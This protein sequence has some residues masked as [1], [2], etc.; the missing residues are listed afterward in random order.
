MRYR[1]VICS[2]LGLAS[3]AVALLA[4]CKLDDLGLGESRRLSAAGASCLR[5]D[6]CVPGTQCIGQVCVDPSAPSPAPAPAPNPTAAPPVASPSGAPASPAPTVAEPAGVPVGEVPNAQG[7]GAATVSAGPL[8]AG[9]E[10][11]KRS[12]EL[13]DQGYQHRQ[14]GDNAAARAAYQAALADSPSNEAARYNLACELA[15]T[16]DASDREEAVSHLQALLRQNT[17]VAR[18]FIAAVRFDTDFSS[19]A[20]DPRV[21]EL[22]SSVVVDPSQPLWPQLCDDP[23][24]FVSLVDGQTGLVEYH[25]TMTADESIKPIGP[26]T[27]ARTWNEARQAAVAFLRDMRQELCALAADEVSDGFRKA[28]LADHASSGQVCLIEG[29]DTEYSTAYELCI[30]YRDGWRIALLSRSP[31]GPLDSDATDAID[32]RVG[33]ARR[34]GLALYGR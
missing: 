25:E 31:G 13:N 9:G 27:R 20:S 18:S 22:V 33:A 15:L 34:K 4:A 3:G 2:A 32:R 19:L 11:S 30:V 1:S 28:R 14:R 16:G 6:D 8:A 29:T 21:R 5:T 10:A 17:R 7:G 12:K 26:I 23:G 24:R